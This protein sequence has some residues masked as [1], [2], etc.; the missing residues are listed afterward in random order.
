MAPS[1]KNVVH[2]TLTYTRIAVLDLYESLHAL[3]VVHRDVQPRHIRLSRKTRRPMLIDLDG[4]MVVQSLAGSVL[5]ER[6]MA[7]VREKLG[8]L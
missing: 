4:A 8:M 3:G 7:E 5:F 2:L 6:E 1:P